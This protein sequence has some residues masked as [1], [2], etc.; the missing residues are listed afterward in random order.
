M[1]ETFIELDF[2]TQEAQEL[3]AAVSRHCACFVHDQAGTIE[4]AGHRGLSEQS[5]LKRWLFARRMREVWRNGELAA[6]TERRVA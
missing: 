6:Y 1:S 5:E 2:S 3:L 4:C